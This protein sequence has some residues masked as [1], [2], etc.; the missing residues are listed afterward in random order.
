LADGQA[1]V[2]AIDGGNSKTD[3]ALIGWDGSVLAARR[4]PGA[5]H[6]AH[7]VDGAMRR[8]G[9]QIR[10]VAD[11]AGIGRS[12]VIASHVSACLAGAD[13]P[14]EEAALT[15]ALL[16]GG[17]S[18]TAV[19]VNDT[20]AV[21]RGGVDEPWGVA[22]TCGAGINC[23][24]VAPSGA[25][26]RYLA[27][28]TLTGDW[29]GGWGLAQAV[30]WHAMR[31]WDG[32]GPATALGAAA[33]DHF[34]LASIRDVAV[35]V[36][37]R[38]LAESDLHRLTGVLF[39]VAALGDPVARSLVTQQATEICV[40]AAAAMRQLGMTPA[41]TPVVLG[42]GLLESRD[43]LLLA[44]VDRQLAE[45]APGASSRVLDVPPVAGAALLGLDYVGAPTTPKLRLRGCY[46]A[47]SA[48]GGGEGL[49]RHRGGGVG[50][51]LELGRLVLEA[52]KRRVHADQGELALNDGQVR[53]PD[54]GEDAA[55]VGGGVVPAF[56]RGTRPVG[57]AADDDEHGRLARQQRLVGPLGAR[58]DQVDP[59][60]DVLRDAEVVERDGEQHRVRG[61]QLIGQADREGQG[62]A[63]LLGAGLFRGPR[64]PE[65]AR[66]GGRR[67]RLGAEVLADDH[68][69]GVPG[70]PLGL[71][72]VRDGAAR[73]VGRVDAGVEAEQGHEGVPPR[74][75][76]SIGAP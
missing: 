43:P 57:A 62:G 7:G 51:V 47:V 17:W 35:A 13:L 69:A 29:G 9:E 27:L 44:E 33:A 68:A 23:V 36:H 19:A 5:S 49:A 59:G 28:G 25:V 72:D 24:A 32:R 16:A 55:Q 34:G 71:D 65:R 63:L 38:D 39:A 6:E 75:G 37:K 45:A 64:G 73:R 66:P 22:V 18:Q 21:L 26:A 41:G 11:K 67:Q 50:G 42:G 14:E 20:F 40:M 48:L 12:G 74:S 30:M 70:L 76:G 31:G 8:L 2:L 52:V 61:A 1:A 60:L 56:A 3:V 58:Y 54:I 46:R 15:A 10:A 4:G 53:A